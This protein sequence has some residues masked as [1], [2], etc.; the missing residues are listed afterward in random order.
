MGPERYGEPE[1]G[2]RMLSSLY[3]T[4]K[5]PATSQGADG[6]KD[7]NVCTLEVPEES[8]KKEQSQEEIRRIPFD[9]RD[10]M[11]IGRSI[12]IYVDAML[13]KS[14][15]AADHEAN[16]R[17]SFENLPRRPEPIL[18]QGQKAREIDSERTPECEL[19]F[20]QLKA[21]LQPP[22]LLS[23]PLPEMF[24]SSIRLGRSQH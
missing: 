2:T 1:E 13:I 9:E 23:R 10:P 3:K 6:P 19:S 21:Y 7:R 17:E 4:H 5:G 16:L 24:C 20:R 22:Q 12:E 8:L 11:K 18:V 14:R 15:E